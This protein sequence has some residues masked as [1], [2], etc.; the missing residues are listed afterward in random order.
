MI[1]QNIISSFIFLGVI[2]ISLNA[3][4]VWNGDLATDNKWN[5]VIG[6]EIE[7]RKCSAV[8]VHPQVLLTAAHCFN[9]LSSKTKV[10]T[11][12]LS[13]N[14]LKKTSSVKARFYAHPKFDFDFKGATGK[15]SDKEFIKAAQNTF[16]DIAII[17]LSN[18]ITAVSGLSEAKGIRLVT[19]NDIVEV[20]ND[21]NVF[22]ILGLGLYNGG[23]ETSSANLTRRIINVKKPV[24]NEYNLFKTYPLVENQGACAGDSGGALVAETYS[25]MKLVGVLSAAGK[26]CGGARPIYMSYV[27]EH[28]C[29]I[30]KTSQ[31]AITGNP[32]L[33]LN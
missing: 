1:R 9:H 12:S 5:M 26:P 25:G 28:V 22:S 19:K 24:L 18:D 29:W 7:G 27:A 3:N 23:N 11:F 4:C 15:P 21:H 33:C 8:I 17:K 14:N 30:Q 10:Y 32:Q 6:Y 31:I 13:L 20:L 16:N 2:S